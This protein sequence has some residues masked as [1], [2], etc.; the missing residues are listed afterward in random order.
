ML[1]ILFAHKKISRA[2][3]VRKLIIIIPRLTDQTICPKANIGSHRGLHKG[4]TILL[5]VIVYVF[6]D[7]ILKS[8]LIILF[9]LTT[10]VQ[11]SIVIPA[12]Y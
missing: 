9:I 4:F 7:I 3:T 8:C 1:K 12:L 11:N 5:D 10:L 6:V 2:F